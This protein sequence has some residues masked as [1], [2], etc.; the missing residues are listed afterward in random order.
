MCIP[1]VCFLPIYQPRNTRR[2]IFSGNTQ[3]YILRE[4]TG[5]YREFFH[6]V[7]DGNHRKYMV[8]VIVLHTPPPLI[9]YFPIIIYPLQNQAIFPYD[10]SVA[11]PCTLRCCRKGTCRI[12]SVGKQW[13]PLDVV[14]TKIFQPFVLSCC[15]GKALVLKWVKLSFWLF[16]HPGFWTLLFQVKRLLLWESF[17]QR[18]SDSAHDMELKW[19]KNL[20]ILCSQQLLAFQLNCFPGIHYMT[21]SEQRRLTS[22]KKKDSIVKQM[23]SPLTWGAQNEQFNLWK[24]CFLSG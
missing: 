20:G 11:W 7:Q 17:T 19:K 15:V 8:R 10:I 1:E 3:I 16:I 18:A 24:T 6:L 23:G 12:I 13:A 21:V 2:A 22:K 9:C 4:H 14:N 5:T